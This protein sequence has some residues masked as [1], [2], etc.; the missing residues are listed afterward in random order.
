MGHLLN[1]SHKYH[2]LKHLALQCHVLYSLLP[3][4][5]MYYVS[6]FP[7]LLHIS[8]ND[9]FHNVG[10]LQCD[11]WANQRA[12][13]SKTHS[14]CN[15]RHCLI[16]SALEWPKP[17]VLK[18][19]LYVLEVLPRRGMQN[20][21]YLSTAPWQGMGKWRCRSLIFN[22]G[23]RWKWSV[24]FTL[25]LLYTRRHSRWYPVN[26]REDL[27]QC[28]RC[29]KPNQLSIC[30]EL[31]RSASVIL[32]AALSLFRLRRPNPSW[33]CTDPKSGVIILSQH[34]N[35]IFNECKHPYWSTRLLMFAFYASNIWPDH[36]EEFLEK[37]SACVWKRFAPQDGQGLTEL[38]Y[39]FQ[40]CST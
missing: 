34:F 14:K 1:A 7:K 32:A 39:N 12:W 8:L 19:N 9:S 16:C 5:Y 33:R 10:N 20:V 27:S 21:A 4:R 24:V 28:G 30:Q 25:L 37:N 40:S 17:K 18:I 23:S 6:V 26:S 15:E 3:G 11:T 38:N 35:R 29:R 22:L 2:C 36:T 31:H 13:N